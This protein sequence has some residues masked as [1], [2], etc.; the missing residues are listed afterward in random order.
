MKDWRDNF[1]DEE[2]EAIER[3]DAKG[4]CEFSGPCD[5][6]HCMECYGMSNSDFF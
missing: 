6:G 1:S 5:C 2:L 4:D 3:D